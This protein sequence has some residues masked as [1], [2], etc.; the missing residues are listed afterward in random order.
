MT[1]PFGV[2]EPAP[3]ARP[4]GPTSSQPTGVP[5]GTVFGS[6]AT[7]AFEAHGDD[8]DSTMAVPQQRLHGTLYGTGGYETIDTTMPVSMNAVENSGSLTGHILAQG[9]HDEV[10]DRRR[11]N[12]KVAVAMLIVL[13]LLVAVS[14]VFL[15]TAG[16]SFSDMIG[17]M[18]E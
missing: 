13:G 12:L 10:V 8:I 7:T 6:P 1:T 11:G 3:S 4:F 9:W 17:K 14:V 2:G 18:F 15:L 5:A 16:S